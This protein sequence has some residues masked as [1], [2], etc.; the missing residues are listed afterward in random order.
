VDTVDTTTA[1]HQ[2][3]AIISSDDITK[4]NLVNLDDAIKRVCLI[5]LGIAVA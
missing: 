4:H 1:V 5:Y 3:D 2:I